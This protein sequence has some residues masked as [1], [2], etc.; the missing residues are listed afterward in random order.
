[1]I[2]PNTMDLIILSSTSKAEFQAKLKDAFNNYVSSFPLK[3]F[4]LRKLEE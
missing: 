1:L 4:S 3:P 2:D